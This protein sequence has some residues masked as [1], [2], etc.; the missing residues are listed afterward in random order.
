MR[1][2]PTA[3]YGVPVKG[4]GRGYIAAELTPPLRDDPAFVA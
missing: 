2:A 1:D 4:P 3:H